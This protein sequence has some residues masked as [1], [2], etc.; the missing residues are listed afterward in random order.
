M[1]DYLS[2]SSNPYSSYLTHTY[3][4][5]HTH[6][7]CWWNILSPAII[8]PHTLPLSSKH[9]R[10]GKNTERENKCMYKGTWLPY[11]ITPQPGFRADRPGLGKGSH[12]PQPGLPW[13]RLLGSP[14]I[15]SAS[16][17]LL[18]TS[19]L[20]EKPLSQAVWW[21]RSSWAQSFWITP[22]PDGHNRSHPL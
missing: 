11:L 12:T 16:C 17:N 9:L 3:T 10:A 4:F 20:F 8:S 2:C 1:N 13:C 19:F 18:D 6:T 5:V 14:S 22:L 7:F 21:W 15:L